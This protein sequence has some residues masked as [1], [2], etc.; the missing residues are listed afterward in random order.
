MNIEKIVENAVGIAMMFLCM[1]IVAIGVFGGVFLASNA[2]MNNFVAWPSELTLWK[3]FLPAL[4][5]CLGIVVA[6]TAVLALLFNSDEWN[7]KLADKICVLLKRKF[8][9]TF[10]V[11][12]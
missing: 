12:V 4:W 10:S 7:E 8:P 2:S 1:A 3:K 6:I 9:R 11:L 5:G